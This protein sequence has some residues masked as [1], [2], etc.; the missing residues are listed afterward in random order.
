MNQTLG[1][2]YLYRA[3]DMTTLI[4]W[5]QYLERLADTQLVRSMA[6]VGIKFVLKE[7]T[8]LNCES[9]MYDKTRINPGAIA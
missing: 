4:L 7:D 3:H 8:I 2:K 9:G 1:I 6:G 5:R